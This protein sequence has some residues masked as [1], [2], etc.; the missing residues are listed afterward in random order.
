MPE[1]T[2]RNEH[3]PRHICAETPYCL[4]AHFERPHLSP[5]EIA[6]LHEQRM[7][8]VAVCEEGRGIR[9]A[10]VEIAQQLAAL[11]ANLTTLNQRIGG[12]A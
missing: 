5:A 9:I 6:M 10:L 4:V 8:R 7:L 12:G 11:N 3:R 1:R 2:N